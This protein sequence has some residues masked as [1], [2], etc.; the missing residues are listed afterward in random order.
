MSY[1]FL[2]V[3]DADI[4]AK[5]V[6]SVPATDFLIEGCWELLNEFR[7]FVYDYWAD[8]DE[9]Y[10]GYGDNDDI[11]KDCGGSFVGLVDAKMFRHEF[12]EFVDEWF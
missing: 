12:V 5:F 1:F 7:G 2:E 11:C 10:E 8:D 9:N 4:A 6:D 3:I